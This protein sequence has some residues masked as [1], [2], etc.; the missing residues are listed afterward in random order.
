MAQASGSPSPTRSPTIS[1]VRCTFTAI[2][3]PEASSLFSSPWRQTPLAPTETGLFSLY[4]RFSSRFSDFEGRIYAGQHGSRRFSP[5]PTDRVAPCELVSTL[6]PAA[7]ACQ[8]FS[9]SAFSSNGLAY[10]REVR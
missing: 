9:K 4:L 7:F 8:H 6:R 3:M 2:P 1:E 5:L 10:G